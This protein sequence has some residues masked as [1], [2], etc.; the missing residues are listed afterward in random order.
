MKFLRI[1]LSVVILFIAVVLVGMGCLIYFVDPN[2]LRPVIV[3]AVEIK[4]GYHVTIDDQLSWSFY[5]QFSVKIKQLSIST[6]KQTPPFADLSDVKIATNLSQLLKRDEKLTGKV[7]V[8][9]LRLFKLRAQNANI[10][11]QWKDKTLKFNPITASLYNGSF[12]GVCEGSE[13][14][15]TPK[16]LLSARLHGIQMK[17]LLDDV[18]PNNKIKLSGQSRITLQAVTKGKNSSEIIN[19]F[20][21]IADFALDN[22]EIEGIDLNYF[23][24][25]ADALLNKQPLPEPVDIQRTSFESLTGSSVILSGR[26]NTNNLLLISSAFTT[27]GQGYLDLLHQTINLK[28]Q[29]ASQQSIKAKWKIP[30]IIEGGLSHPMV[31]LNTSAIGKFIMEQEIEQ[32]KEKVR[33]HIQE[34]VRGA[35]GE[36][37]QKLLGN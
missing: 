8:K 19:N 26:V 13:F 33:T 35:A 25:T 31:R 24:K 22:G 37:L 30:I 20:N 9:T 5:P 23:I 21:G 12:A 36:F 7:Y 27:K 34:H 6:S 10:G 16:W 29:I 17:P 1:L 11:L 14:S 32:A 3:K 18:N 28:L 2:N 4:T 15:T